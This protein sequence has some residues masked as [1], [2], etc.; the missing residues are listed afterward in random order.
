M[1]DPFKSLTKFWVF[2]PGS[3]SSLT[4]KAIQPLTTACRRPGPPRSPQLCPPYP[5]TP[6]PP[7]LAATAAASSRHDPTPRNHHHVKRE[8]VNPRRGNFWISL[9][10]LNKHELR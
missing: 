4:E 7:F 8:D 2:I 1:L 10:T 3:P 6:V 9:G 5:I